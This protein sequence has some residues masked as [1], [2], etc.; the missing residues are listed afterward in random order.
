MMRSLVLRQALRVFPKCCSNTSTQKRRGVRRLRQPLFDSP[1][2]GISP[3]RTAHEEER[4]GCLSVLDRGRDMFSALCL[5]EFK[6]ELG[7]ADG[8][9]KHSEA[10][11][12]GWQLLI[13]FP[14]NCI[15]PH[16]SCPSVQLS[17]ALNLH[18]PPRFH[19]LVLPWWRWMSVC[20]SK[21]LLPQWCV[22][23]KRK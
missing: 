17:N 18:T 23:P 8:D 1:Q 4:E 9:P 12:V 22:L 21:A 2:P 14:H 15:W 16:L 20:G 11:L 7:L 6:D 13:P 10:L 19:T 5:Q 3:R